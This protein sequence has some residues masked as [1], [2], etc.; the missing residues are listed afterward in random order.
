VFV[1]SVLVVC[2]FPFLLAL[3]RLVW[4]CPLR[5]LVVSVV[6]A[7]ARG[8]RWLLLLALVWLAWFSVLRRL[9]VGVL[10]PLVVGGFGLLL[11][12]LVFSCLSSSF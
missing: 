12:L 4:F 6:P 10:F 8:L 3:V 9:P 11:F 1:L 2:G 5:L 7:P